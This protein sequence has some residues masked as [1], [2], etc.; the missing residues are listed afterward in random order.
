MIDIFLVEFFSG[1]GRGGHKPEGIPPQST[2]ERTSH[3]FLTATNTDTDTDTHLGVVLREFN[4]VGDGLQVLH[5]RL[6]GTVET[7]PDADG[8]DT[9]V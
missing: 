3:T 5:R 2:N 7:L 9:P 8:V 4:R 1:G 6:T